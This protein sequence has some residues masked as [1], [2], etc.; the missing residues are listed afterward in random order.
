MEN[1][2]SFPISD[3]L[4]KQFAQGRL[5]AETE[6][7]IAVAI[8]K[9]LELQSRL[10]ALS[11]DDFLDRVKQIAATSRMPTSVAPRPKAAATIASFSADSI[12]GVPE[13]LMESPDYQVLEEIG[14]GGMGVVYAAKYLPMD[15][16]E[17]LKVLN[18]RLV[19]KE[20]A[21]QRFIREMRAI[22]KLNHPFIATA[23]QRAHSRKRV[24]RDIKPSNVMVFEEDGKLQMKVLDFGLAKATS[25]Q[26][27][28]GF[29]AAGSML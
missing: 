19:Q 3:S 4:L 18:E 14:R 20:S 15:R 1:Q 13:E 22:G 9:S 17:V 16:I 6:V 12:A 25:E 7:K 23:C 21:R 27:A 2:K 24:H 26:Q 5:N 8:E 28:E 11:S 29:T 10:A